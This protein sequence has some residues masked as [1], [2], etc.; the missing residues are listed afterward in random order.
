MIVLVVNTRGNVQ[1]IDHSSTDMNDESHI[2]CAR[3]TAAQTFDQHCTVY[4]HML[5]QQ[6][7]NVGN[8]RPLRSYTKVGV[9]LVD[10]RDGA[11][12]WTANMLG[13]LWAW[14]VTRRRVCAGQRPV[15][16]CRQTVTVEW[17]ALSAG[18]GRC[19]KCDVSPWRLQCCRRS[20]ITNSHCPTQNT[21]LLIYTTLLYFPQKHPEKKR[22]N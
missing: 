19:D 18:R 1:V 13:C 17:R 14:G 4:Q 2:M 6:K 20:F 8:I 11:R 12:R 15:A 10:N 22:Y 9:S 7:P 5:S 3:Q 16:G 21:R